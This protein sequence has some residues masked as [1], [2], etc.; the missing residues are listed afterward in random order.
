MQGWPGS[1]T[2]DKVPICG[3]SEVS[4]GQKWRGFHHLVVEMCVRVKWKGASV[5]NTILETNEKYVSGVRRIY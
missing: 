5:K 2:V 3:N 1:N 4:V